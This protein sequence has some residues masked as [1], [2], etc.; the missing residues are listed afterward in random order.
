MKQS[1]RA[2]K[3]PKGG[4]KSGGTTHPPSFTAT[5]VVSKKVRFI[6]TAAAAAD[7]LTSDSFG[8][9]LGVAVSTTSVRPVASHIRVRK[10]EMWG[11]MSS[12]LAPVTVSVEWTGAQ[13]FA[14]S[15][16]ISDTSMGSNEPAHVVSRPPRGTLVAD[17]IDQQQ[18]FAMCTLAY[19][20]NAVV[21]VTYDFAVADDGVPLPPRVVVGATAG[22]VY[23][24]ALNS[25]ANNNLVPVSLATI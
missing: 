10:I 18:A 17:W 21:D 25:P 20:A 3:A 6:A 4:S 2:R 9:L 5:F 13:G 15:N 8:Q 22:A 24:A 16:R 14:K 19:P 7:A 12:T 11:P 23:V 1:R